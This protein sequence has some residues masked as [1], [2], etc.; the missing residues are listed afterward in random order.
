MPLTL[1]PDTPVH[2]PI[3]VEEQQRSWRI[4]AVDDQAV[5]LGILQQFLVFDCHV[6][7]TALDGNEALEKFRA[8]VDTPERF[9]LVITDQAM[10]HL[11]GLQLAAAVKALAPGT[12]VILLTGLLVRD[13]GGATG[14]PTVDLTLLKPVTQANLRAAIGRLMAGGPP[15]RP[16]RRGQQH[17]RDAGTIPNEDVGQPAARRP[18]KTATRA[19][20]LQRKKADG[21]RARV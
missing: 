16:L 4:L 17:P 7:E 20:G 19:R 21:K 15:R 6:V 8:R 1:P 5:F 9:D 10:P 13:E 18:R 3:A 14:N 12:R 2:S 11:T